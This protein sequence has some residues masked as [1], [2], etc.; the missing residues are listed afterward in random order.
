MVHKIGP[1]GD[2]YDDAVPLYCTTGSAWIWHRTRRKFIT[3][4][5]LS[6][7]AT[8]ASYTWP[9]DEVG[10]PP[11]W[12]QMTHDPGVNWGDGVTAGPPA[13]NAITNGEA[14]A[15]GGG[16]TAPTD[17]TK[18]GTPTFTLTGGVLYVIHGGSGDAG[19]SQSVTTVAA[20]Q[21]LVYVK[22]AAVVGSAEIKVGTVTW[23]V[24]GTG[25]AAIP[26]TAAGAATVVQV[27]T[28]TAGSQVWVDYV[29]GIPMADAIGGGQTKGPDSGKLLDED[30]PPA[31]PVYTASYAHFPD[32]LTGVLSWNIHVDGVD[33]DG[34]DT[35]TD[36]TRADAVAHIVHALNATPGVKALP[37]DVVM[38]VHVMP[39]PGV[40]VS[41]LA[42]GFDPQPVTAKPAKKAKPKP[43]VDPELEA[44]AAKE[45]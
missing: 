26:V 12:W 30:T 13:T 40:A 34:V 29:R 10:V 37:N 16:A 28:K 21:Y 43:V 14:W 15:G 38:A 1:T 33:Y 7:L 36:M 23:P 42:I 32:M 25:V 19:M 35:V 6:A 45:T 4:S 27:I 5:S 11:V 20:T 31:P 39:E 8:A 18:V 24:S 2:R 3:W 22:V 17:W 9:A 41:S 44:Q